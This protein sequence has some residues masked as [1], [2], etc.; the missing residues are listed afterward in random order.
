MRV[1]DTCVAV[2]HGLVN[3]ALK[4]V[5][6]SRIKADTYLQLVFILI[7]TVKG[8]SFGNYDK[9]LAAWIAGASIFDFRRIIKCGEGEKNMTGG[10]HPPRQKWL[11]LHPPRFFPK[12]QQ[13][14]ALIFILLIPWWSLTLFDKTACLNELSWK[15]SYLLAFYLKKKNS[16]FAW[17]WF[18]FCCASIISIITS[19]KNVCLYRL[20]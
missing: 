13:G 19:R 20:L 3:S 2:S 11:N 17:H 5:I 12:W 1:R 14:L 15:N 10:R 6:Q 8:N 18:D 9:V 7:R 16:C 4:M